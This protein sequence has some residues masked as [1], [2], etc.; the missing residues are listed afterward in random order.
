MK[1]IF[2]KK[3]GNSGLLLFFA[4]WGADEHLFTAPVLDGYDCMLCY[5]YRALDFDSS[6]LDGYASVRLLAWSMGVWVAQ[7]VASCLKLNYDRKVAVNG[8]SYP[9][10]DKKGIP[11]A[12]FMGTL[13][14]ISVP[15]LYKFRR[16]MCGSAKELQEF[17]ARMPQRALEELRDELAALQRFVAES[18]AGDA[19]FWD[20][21]IAGKNDFIFPFEN[22]MNAW[23]NIHVQVMDIA[24][25]DT[26]LFADLLRKEEMWTKH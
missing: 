3:E 4:G 24:H 6:L 19:S 18:D 7:H 11:Y 15:T 2:L 21:A 20:E 17:T 14:G 5:D 13:E 23:K 16:R 10:D 26:S 9:I 1:Q 12:V 8:T 22:Q 25:Y